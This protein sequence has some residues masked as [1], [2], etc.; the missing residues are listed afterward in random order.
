VVVRR[1]AVNWYDG[2]KVDMMQAWDA[3]KEGRP[4]WALFAAHQAVEK[5]IQV[6]RPYRV[7]SG[8]GP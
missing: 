5:A 2:A 8:V 3:L 7:M 1:E 4:N 6:A